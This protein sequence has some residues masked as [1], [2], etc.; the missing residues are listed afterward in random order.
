MVV[1]SLLQR[2]LDDITIPPGIPLSSHFGLRA[3]LNFRYGRRCVCPSS[4]VLGKNIDFIDLDD[5]DTQI[6][7][8]CP[9]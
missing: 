8:F 1:I 9:A 3:V 7:D 5:I 4:D 6:E 2:I